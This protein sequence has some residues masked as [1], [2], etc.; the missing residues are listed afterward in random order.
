MRLTVKNIISSEKI[1]KS[2][3][4][5]AA[6][7]TIA[8]PALLPAFE[9][10]VMFDKSMVENV[11]IDFLTV[12]KFILLSTDR[13]FRDRYFGN[14][15]DLR[16]NYRIS[17]KT[18]ATVASLDLKLLE[19]V[20]LDKNWDNLGPMVD[21]CHTKSN[22]TDEVSDGGLTHN[23][24]HDKGTTCLDDFKW[25]RLLREYAL[26]AE[27]PSRIVNPAISENSF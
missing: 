12:E 21:G 26:A 23:D 16:N 10:T 19:T 27:N 15:K 14:M 11:K 22:H 18:W 8:S 13:E 1:R 7:L 24:S 9:T 25:D 4:L 6:V 5:P 20:I 2:I 17:E 3:I